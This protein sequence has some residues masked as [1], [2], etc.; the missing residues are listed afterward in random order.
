VLKGI[1]ER[2]GIDHGWKEHLKTQR[3][4]APLYAISDN[5]RGIFGNLCGLIYFKS[6]H[7]TPKD[8]IL[9]EIFESEY[10]HRFS[11]RYIWPIIYTVLAGVVTAIL[12]WFRILTF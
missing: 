10:R 4:G 5:L 3:K 8:K 2:K 6:S 9:L 7:L 12:F 1:L 11:R